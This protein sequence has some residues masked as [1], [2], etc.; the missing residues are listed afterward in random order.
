MEGGNN[1]IAPLFL[2][3]GGPTLA[4]D[5][6]EYTKFL[7]G[8]RNQIEPKAIVI[9][10]AHWESPITT[11]SYLDSTYGMIY[12]FYGFPEEL[13]RIKYSAKGS[14]GVAA[15]LE[16]MLSENGIESK[17]DYK[18]GIDHGAWVMLHIMYPEANIPVIQVSVNPDLEMDKQ[19]EIGKALRSLGEEDILVI[20]SGSTVHNL[21]TIDWQAEKPV[22]WAVEFD[23]WLMDKIEK[24]NTEMLF[25][26][27]RLAPYAKQA[28]PREEHLVPLFIAMGS[29]QENSVPEVLHRSYEFGSLSYICIQ[30]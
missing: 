16:A 25:N 23:D 14:T 9:F 3:H 21:S 11:I 7:R 29:G 10:T 6:N 8:L 27:R 13:Y 15:K 26:Y 24:K 18:R 4:I 19:F 28:V 12:D 1:M 22:N 30:F 20:G 2:C 17:F 5:T